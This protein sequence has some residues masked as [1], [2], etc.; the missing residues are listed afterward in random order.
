MREIKF[1]C[2]YVNKNEWEKDLVMLTPNG[3]ICQLKNDIHIPC[4]PKTHII[5]LFTGLRDKNGREMYEGDILSY[6]YFKGKFIVEWLF[7]GWT[8]RG[9]VPEE[10]REVR[11]FPPITMPSGNFEY[12]E[13]VGNIY[14]NP[15][16][17]KE[18]K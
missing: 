14:E 16:L 12:I 9:T 15:E 13:V 18:P 5:Q 1:R 8:L 4:N 3:G 2:W 6:E 17:L 10:E 7:W 11:T